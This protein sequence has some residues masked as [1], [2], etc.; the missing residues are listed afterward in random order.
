M[1]T[2]ERRRDQYMIYVPEKYLAREFGYEA[3]SVCPIVHTRHVSI[4]G[5]LTETYNSPNLAR[6]RGV[7][8][9][10]SIN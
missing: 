8:S 1:G 5:I 9:L 3:P 6:F 4:Y 2:R 7:E 10:R